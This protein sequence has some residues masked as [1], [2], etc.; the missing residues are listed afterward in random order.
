MRWSVLV[1]ALV[2]ALV[3]AVVTFLLLRASPGIPN[4]HGRYEFHTEGSGMYFFDTQ[5]GG[6][7]VWQCSGGDCAKV[8]ASPTSKP[9]ATK[10]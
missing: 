1:A 5:T 8:V 2:S 3:S 6:L 9:S 4:T 10:E 7:T